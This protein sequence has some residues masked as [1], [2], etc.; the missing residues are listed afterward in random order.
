MKKKAKKAINIRPKDLKERFLYIRRLIFYY[1]L[2]IILLINIILSQ[3]IPSL[4]FDFI[5]G[6]QDAAVTLLRRLR[7]RPEFNETYEEQYKIFG[8]D[9]R[10]TIYGPELSRKEQIDKL[11]GIIQQYPQSRDALYGLYKL[12]DEG[13]NHDRAQFYLEK[14]KE[15]DPQVDN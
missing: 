4:Y 8:E 13:G 9:F 5:D 15:I 7:N 1:G 12:Y 6:N 14:A 10:S 11:E 3:S 2:F